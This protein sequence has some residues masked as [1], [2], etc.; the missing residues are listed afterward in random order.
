MK[1]NLLF[2]ALAATTM[3]FATS[4][5]QDEV[6]V[7][8][9]ESIVTFEVGTPQMATR[10]NYSDGMTATKLQWAVYNED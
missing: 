5:Q 8:G 7:D 9:N 10:A 1:K 6:F 2:T 4:C 3:L